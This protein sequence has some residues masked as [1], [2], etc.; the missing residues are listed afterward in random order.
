[1][2]LLHGEAVLFER[3][4]KLLGVL[5]LLALILYLAWGAAGRGKRN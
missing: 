3:L 2:L 1:M 4:L 5:V